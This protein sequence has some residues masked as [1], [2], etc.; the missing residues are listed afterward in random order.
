MYYLDKILRL[1]YLRYLGYVFVIRHDVRNLL[2][3]PEISP[4]SEIR[5]PIT[6]SD[7]SLIS[8]I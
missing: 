3:G 7:I 2:D 6:T 8:D 4:K 5:H 1:Y